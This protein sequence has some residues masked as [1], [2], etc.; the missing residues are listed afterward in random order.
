MQEH[1]STGNVLPIGI[2]GTDFCYMCF[3]KIQPIPVKQ[4]QTTNNLFRIRV[5]TLG[6]S[7]LQMDAEGYMDQTISL[8]N[9]PQN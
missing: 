3:E 7:I 6:Y 9:D 4:D 8:E 2:Q 1:Q 5:F